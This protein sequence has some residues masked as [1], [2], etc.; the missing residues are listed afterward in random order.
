MEQVWLLFGGLRDEAS[1]ALALA[2]LAGLAWSRLPARWAQHKAMPFMAAVAASVAVAALAWGAGPQADD[3]H[4]AWLGREGWWGYQVDMWR[5]WAGRYLATAVL[6]A[7]PQPFGFLPGYIALVVLTW[8]VLVSGIVALLWR[9]LPAGWPSGERLAI[10]AWLWLAAVAG[11]PNWAEGVVW[12][13]GSVTYSLPLGMAAWGFALL[14]APAGG[15]LV[16][17][18]LGMLLAVLA[19]GAS[20]LVAGGTAVSAVALAIWAWR[21][22]DPRR[23]IFV[24]GALVILAAAATAALAPGNR[25]R[26]HSTLILRTEPLTAVTI[27]RVAREDGCQ[28]WSASLWPATLLALAMAASAARRA[29]RTSGG[30]SRAGM[31]ALI[32]AA[33]ALPIAVLLLGIPAAGSG[34]IPAR[35]HNNAWMAVWT[36]MA[37]AAVAGGA[38]LA[39]LGPPVRLSASPVAA[40]AVCIVATAAAAIGVLSLQELLLCLALAGC[41]TLA[42]GRRRAVLA[43]SAVTLI[44]IAS[45]MSEVLHDL[46]LLPAQHAAVAE[47]DARCRSAMAGS[48]LVLPVFDPATAPRSCIVFDLAVSVHDQVCLDTA[49]WYGLATIHGDVA[50]WRPQRSD[51]P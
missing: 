31:L 8:A 20:E 43:G 34:W 12:L 21:Y 38:W 45:S 7:W 36:C 2:L 6:S 19:C 22:E 14:L 42:V 30:S 25:E 47:R 29:V 3:Y 33:A 17:R 51:R 37:V 50:P 46:P 5:H 27:L 10:V 32:A 1:G 11:W 48:D 39:R 23:R 9:L 49:R 24:A 41:A 40:L 44:I 28:V 26:Q 18:L 13:S 35:V 15:R 4:H 16:P